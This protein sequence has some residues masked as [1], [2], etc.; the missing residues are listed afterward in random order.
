MALKR[1]ITKAEFDALPKDIQ[2]EYLAD[3][4]NYK[5]DIAGDEDTGALKRAKDREKQL[6]QEAE[7]KLK[8]AQEELDRI[9]G[10]DA[11]KKGDIATLEKSWQ[12]KLDD[13]KAEYDGKLT[14]RDAALKKSL[15]DDAAL[16]I[17]TKISSAPALI[18]PHIKARLQADLDG[19]VP[20]TKVLDL[21]GVVSTAT[22]DDLEKEIIANKEFSAIIIAGKGSGGSTKNDQNRGS[23]TKTNFTNTNNDAP[24]PAHKQSAKDLA[25]ALKERKEAADE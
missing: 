14:K 21:N 13:Q 5:L 3:G 9:N 15:I 7:D 16:K 24:I 19:D 20:A 18:L 10:D 22:L 4:D 23:A 1:S 25:A 12:K 6:R 8:Q 11:R 17:A 2:T